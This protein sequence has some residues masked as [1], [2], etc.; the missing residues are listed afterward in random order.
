MSSNGEAATS[1]AQRRGVRIVLW[2]E[3]YV[4]ARFAVLPELP[5]L[6]PEGAPI[7]LTVGHGE[8]SLIAP[9]AVV[10]NLAVAATALSSGW[11]ALTL[12]VVFP[13]ATVGVLA[14][15]GGALARIG[16]PVLAFSSHDTDHLLVPASLLGRALAA[17]GQ[18]DMRRFLP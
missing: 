6:A 9:Q 12:D 18:I 14:A 3:P 10:E 1:P 7:S 16:V 13:L 4:V 5:A 8:I 2:P 17:L 15:I 11:R